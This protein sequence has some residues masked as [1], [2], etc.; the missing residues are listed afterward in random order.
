M[1]PT[2]HLNG[3]SRETLQQGF[4]KAY[5]AINAAQEAFAECAPNARD[6]YVQGPDAYRRASAEYVR[7]AEAIR[8]A[9]DYA[10]EQFDACEV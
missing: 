7:H 10:L 9:L 3:S 1:K 6:Y 4:E 5:R 2:I 8:A